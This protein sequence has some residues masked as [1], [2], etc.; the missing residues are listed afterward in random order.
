MGEDLEEIGKGVLGLMSRNP[1]GRTY[2]N[3]LKSLARIACTWA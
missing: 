2:K 3:P 1:A